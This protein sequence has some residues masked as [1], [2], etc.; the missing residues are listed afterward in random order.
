[1]NKEYFFIELKLYLKPL[2]EEEQIIIINKYEQLFQEKT[3]EGLSE[4]DI[5]TSLPT[6]KMIATT[7]FKELGVPFNTPHQTNDDWVEISQEDNST[8]I[9][10][11]EYDLPQSK[12]S[13]LFQLAGLFFL[14]FCFMFW[15]IFTVAILIASAWLVVATFILSPLIGLYMIGVAATSYA[16]FQFF[17]SLVLLGIG[18]I[19]FVVGIP[20][21]KGALKLFSIYGKWNM[22]IVRGVA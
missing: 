19:G 11:T 22:R 18:L 5:T 8:D 21:T 13:H 3:E 20:I 10:Y 6:P 16:W 2:P 4:Y 7:I 1:M 12:M 15:F 9:P 14:N 17:V